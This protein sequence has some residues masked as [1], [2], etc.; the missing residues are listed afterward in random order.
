MLTLQSKKT[1]GGNRA[2]RQK[3]D[4]NPEKY[5][6]ESEPNLKKYYFRKRPMPIHLIENKSTIYAETEKCSL[7]DESEDVKSDSN[8]SILDA[9]Y[10]CKESSHTIKSKSKYNSEKLSVTYLNYGN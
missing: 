8:E 10:R 3:L 7:A 5:M 2:K 4:A 6:Q 1:E 9:T